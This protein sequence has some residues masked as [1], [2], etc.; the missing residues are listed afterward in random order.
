MKDPPQR[1]QGAL[2]RPQELVCFLRGFCDFTPLRHG[3]LLLGFGLALAGVPVARGQSVWLYTEPNFQ[4]MSREC[5]ADLSA[6]PESPAYRSLRLGRGV[7]VELFSESGF[8]GRRRISYSSLSNLADFIPKSVKL[9]RRAQ[10]TVSRVYSPHPAQGGSRQVIGLAAQVSLENLRVDIAEDHQPCDAPCAD[11]GCPA[12]AG[13]F[14][15][16]VHPVYDRSAKETTWNDLYP[17]E[18]M[19]NTSYFKVC[20]GGGHG[21]HTARCG[22]TSGL[23]L[24]NGV[25]L[26]GPSVPDDFGNLMDAIVFWKDGRAELFRNRDIPND[27]RNAEV[28]FGGTWFFNG[29]EYDCSSCQ[30]HEPD[31]HYARTA[32]G[33]DSSNRT[34]TV[35]VIQLGPEGRNEGVSGRELQALMRKMGVERGLMLDGGGSSQF[36]YIPDDDEPATTVPAGDREGYRPVPSAFG[37]VGLKDVP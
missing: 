14:Y 15:D 10:I 11:P 23:F 35:V 37:I 22:N 5:K 2:G 12:T 32:L 34:L 17:M 18:M 36:V 33:L 4:G 28:G 19:I 3:F 27:L 1:R 16:R 9:H 8:A 6:L 13:F 24:K 29:E 20:A 21:W 7:Y 26:L 25:K 31:A 30:G